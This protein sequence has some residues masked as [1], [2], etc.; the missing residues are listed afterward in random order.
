[1]LVRVVG[2]NAVHPGVL[3]FNDNK[4]IAVNLFRLVNVIVEATIATPSHIQGI[5]EQVVPAGVRAA[6]EKRDAPR[7]AGSEG[8]DKC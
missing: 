4:T 2:N 5:Y 8:A 7:L 6:I 3:D 1:M